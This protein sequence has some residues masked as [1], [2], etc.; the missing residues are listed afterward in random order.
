MRIELT[1]KNYR[2]FPDS[3]PARIIIEDGKWT[4]L[5]GVNNS[6]KSSLL[7]FFYEFRQQLAVLTDK[8]HIRGLVRGAELGGGYPK[9]VRD[10]SEVFHKH[11]SRPL[12]V[13][14]RASATDNDEGQSDRSITGVVVDFSR[15]NPGSMKLR[16]MTFDN[17]KALT[18]SNTADYR[19]DLLHS[20]G[21]EVDVDFFRSAMY[22]LGDTFYIG[23]FRNLL[24]T[25]AKNDYYDIQVGDA[26][27]NQWRE[28]QTG[29]SLQQNMACVEVVEAIQRMFGYERLTIQAANSNDTLHLEI[30]RHAYKLH[31]LG[32]GIAQFVLV[33]ANVAM[34]RPSYLLIDEPEL[35]LHP[36]LQLDFLSTIGGFAKHGV[37]FATH[38]V[39]LARASADRIYAVRRKS[40]GVSE[41]AEWDG[42]RHLPELL[43]ALSYS[44]YQ[45]V[46]FDKVLLVEGTTEV[47]TIQQFLRKLRKDHQV[48]L[49][50]LGGSSFIN[51]DRAHELAELQRITTHLYAV[52]DSERQSAGAVLASDRENFRQTC[53]SLGIQCLVLERRAMDNYLTDAAI[54]QVK[55][56]KY[57]ALGHFD[58]LKRATY[59]WGKHENWRIASEMTLDDIKDTDLGQFL[60]QL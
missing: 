52:I 28:M 24:N 21:A 18:L 54:K 51:G 3:S 13:Q 59:A 1:L 40:Q 38:S 26:F 9:S 47:R 8:S 42:T 15:N 35:N 53:E 5:V 16:S 41:L 60:R 6:G 25:G 22:K 34:R 58:E 50:P 17:D 31:E 19:S 46:G 37:L 4:A 11:N 29:N 14:I 30:D 27:I 32:A 43:G 20:N 33:L 39:G 10:A 12:M 23:S 44:G 45:A 7:R 48:L 57:S 2:C 49:V 36:S 55:G 56:E